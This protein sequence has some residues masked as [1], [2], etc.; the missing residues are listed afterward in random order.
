M[1][2]FKRNVERLIRGA[3]GEIKA[4]LIISGGEMVKRQGLSALSGPAA[5]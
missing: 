2:P 3:A 5:G 4:D 1:K